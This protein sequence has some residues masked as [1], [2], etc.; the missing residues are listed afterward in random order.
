MLSPK[1]DLIKKFAKIILKES[2][3]G[4]YN[5]GEKEIIEILS[6]PSRQKER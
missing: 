6:D 5:Y 1:D 3:W 2:F 4:D